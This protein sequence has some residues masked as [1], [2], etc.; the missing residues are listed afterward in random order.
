MCLNFLAP[1]IPCCQRLTISSNVSP[2]K[3]NTA[4]LGNFSLQTDRLDF[5]WAYTGIHEEYRG[6]YVNTEGTSSLAFLQN[7]YNLNDYQW[8]V[9]NS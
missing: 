7:P 5:D 9:K 4:F 2:D 3:I 6:Y 1:W 8:M